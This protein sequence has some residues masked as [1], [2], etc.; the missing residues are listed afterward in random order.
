[1]YY[2]GIDIGSTAAKTAVFYNG[3][4]IHFFHSLPDGAVWKQQNQF[5]KNSE[6]KESAE[7]TVFLR[8]QDMEE[9]LYLMLIKP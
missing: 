6:R 8:Q 9:F 1:M 2:I 4:F 5:L 3:E 7:K